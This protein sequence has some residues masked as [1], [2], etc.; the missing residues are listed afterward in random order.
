MPPGK[1]ETPAALE[2]RL[3]AG[4][5]LDRYPFL[6]DQ[7]RYEDLAQL[8][9]PDGVI[10]GPV[11]EPGQGRDGITRFFQAS[12][13]RVVEGPLPRLMRHHLTSRTIELSG[14]E[15]SACSYFVA[16]T[17][18][19]PDHWGRYRDKLVKAD[20][21]WRFRRRLLTV[22]GFAPGSWWERNVAVGGS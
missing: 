13:T 17:E 8:F 5:L 4:E 9:T 16:F 14:D 2:D 18:G 1:T 22:D 12:A 7:G 10:E 19:G 20:G 11:G 15:G 21:E 6:V 3:A